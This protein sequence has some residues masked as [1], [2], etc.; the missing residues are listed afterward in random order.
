M[1]MTNTLENIRKY[2]ELA[3]EEM[4]VNI[5]NILYKL[6]KNTGIST[7]SI[8]VEFVEFQVLDQ[9]YPEVRFLAKP[10]PT[11]VVSC[12]KIRTCI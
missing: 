10:T 8:N 4:A 2:T 11:T 7:W 12:V 1:N 5:R 9:E 3:E 6:Q